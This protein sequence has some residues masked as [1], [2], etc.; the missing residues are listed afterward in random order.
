[1]ACIW[2][3]ERGKI[4]GVQDSNG[5]KSPLFEQ[6]TEQFGLE[7]A[8]D[9]YSITQTEDFK[10]IFTSP[11]DLSELRQ[12]QETAKQ[13]AK[14][15]LAKNVFNLSNEQIENKLREL[16]VDS[17]VAKQ[18]A[19]FKNST[20]GFA[21]NS[22]VYLN[23]D[24]ATQA[25]QIH[26]YSHLYNN[27][28]KENKPE[29]YNKGILLIQEELKDEN[30]PIKE[31][32]EF[33]K[34]NQPN[35]KGEAFE[36]EVLTE[37]L[38]RKG[39]EIIN[40]KVNGRSGIIDWIESVWADIKQMLGISKM[41]NEE[42]MNLTLDKYLEAV[43]VD[44]LSGEN[45]KGDY[46]KSPN[47]KPTNLTESQWKQV[48][49]PAFKEWFG[50][51]ENDPENASKVVDENG[52]PLPLMHGSPYSAITEFKR[53]DSKRA[54]PS[55][56]KEFGTY[57]TNNKSLAEMYSKAGLNE[58]T[59]KAIDNEIYK[60]EEI[61]NNSRSNRV[62]NDA[63]ENINLLKARKEGRVYEV[64]LN[65]RDIK[66]F[67]A[68]GK[69]FSG[70]WDELGVESSY[71]YAKN[72]DAMEFLKDGKF[73]VGQVDGIKAEN[74][75]DAFTQ[76]DKKL[77]AKLLGDVYL[78][79]DGRE[80]SIKSA[81]ENIGGFS[82]EN[83]DIRFQKTEPSLNYLMSYIS[84]ENQTEETLS[85]QN[86]IDLQ[87]FENFDKVKVLEAF[88]DEQNIF[89]VNADKLVKSGVYNRYEATNLRDDVSL[90]QEV[91]ESL[92]RLKNTNDVEY[93]DVEITRAST[94]E[95][96]SFGKLRKVNPYIQEEQMVLDSVKMT[97]DEF[98]ENYPQKE[99]PLGFQKEE[100]FLQE[101]E[102]IRQE[103]NTETFR[104]LPLTVKIM[105]NSLLLDR[106]GTIN[107]INTSVLVNN[108][109]ATIKVL[110][111]I[112][113]ELISRGID[114]LGLSELSIDENLK[115]YLEAVRRFVQA[116]TEENTR[117]FADVSDIIFDRDL[118]PKIKAKKTEKELEYVTLN[119]T[120]TEEEVY[121]QQGLI[122]LSG[123]SWVKTAKEDLESLY[124]NVRT[125]KEKFPKG[126]EL[127][128]YVQE[129][130]GAYNFENSETAEAV[131][132]YKIY[133]GAN[134]VRSEQR[135]EDVSDFKGDYEYLTN[136]YVADFNV[137]LLKEKKK[138]SDL[139]RDFYSNFTVNEK[140]INLVNTDSISMQK[141]RLYADENLKNYSLIS[142]QMLNLKERLESPLKDPRV[143]AVNN[144]QSVPT[145]R[146]Q[147]FRAN[148]LEVILKNETSKFVKINNQ[149]Y[150]AVDRVGNISNYIKM[151]ANNTD[152]NALEVPVAQ[153]TIK[154]ED[155]KYLEST[156]Q[157]FIKVK[158]GTRP[159]ELNCI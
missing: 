80:N 121:N 40:E 73:G 129:L 52:E 138:D 6:L 140:G 132:L 16:G 141:V 26:E 35:L 1:M 51:W 84:Q 14:T 15:G 9:Y 119:T 36:D 125:Y 62:Y 71:K 155:Y 41:S 122:R 127:E 7:A 37:L 82:A 18:V 111:E 63:Q 48:R 110:G 116:P 137:E 43:S 31:V 109:E 58:G 157:E 32:V 94:N 76:G 10:E 69:S 114:A 56:L 102:E 149:I 151:E 27:W 117:M 131:A 88:Y 57:F 23:D 158:Q 79:F 60:W 45:I 118:E 147:V 21:I 99:K 17:T 68:K 150:E 30:S 12:K 103:R 55:G 24:V 96:N 92:E 107:S 44:L 42:V 136:D 145:N 53:G 135:M 4:V 112:E 85:P 126:V 78:V 38:G 128:D 74:I 19:E 133:F 2:I 11:K 154:I 115:T 49:T 134:E 105:D 39:L 100:V 28:I 61:R 124:E 139:F 144:P 25:T 152:Y 143:E 159:K 29:V 81:T 72:R 123:N 70:G 156:P 47:G 34:T 130:I 97:E 148:D 59:K 8:I 13:L 146:A 75:V 153:S 67:N 101:G 83:N 89:S 106:I 98:L 113:D 66:T 108:T 46:M 90:Q 95:I 64:F 142:K 3:K 20:A 22:D 120:L 93:Q 50:D 33:V 65:L 86:Q 87:D 104:V 77:E 5:E 54:Q 91:K